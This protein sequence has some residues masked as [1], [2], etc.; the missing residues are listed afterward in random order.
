[1]L[2]YILWC[3]YFGESTF[4]VWAYDEKLKVFTE[5]MKHGRASTFTDGYFLCVGQTQLIGCTYFYHHA[6]SLLRGSTRPTHIATT[7]SLP[8][9]TPDFKI[10]KW[11]SLDFRYLL[12]IHKLDILLITQ[13]TNHLQH[14]YQIIIILCYIRPLLI[15]EHWCSHTWLP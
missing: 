9:K 6:Q 5:I 7:V 3:A 10:Y 15:I 4:K 2:A 11:F 13:V 1:M 8:C 14:A 12:Y